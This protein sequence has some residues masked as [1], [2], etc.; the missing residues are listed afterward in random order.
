MSYE[1][2]VI[3]VCEVPILFGEGVALF[4]RGLLEAQ[5][6]GLINLQPLGFEGVGLEGFLALMMSDRDY[7]VIWLVGS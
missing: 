3:Y 2:I 6:L 1:I 7:R 4:A 5:G